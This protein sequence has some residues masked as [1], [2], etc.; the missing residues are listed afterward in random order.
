[1]QVEIAK[2]RDIR[3][4]YEIV[5]ALEKA[6][7][8]PFVGDRRFTFVVGCPD[9]VACPCVI[10][11][12]YHEAVRLRQNTG[13]VCMQPLFEILS[14]SVES[15]WDPNKTLTLMICGA[16]CPRCGRILWSAKQEK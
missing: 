1:M 3:P 8:V 16:V 14:W 15:K 2:T 11:A 4:K 7:G 9:L 5:Q 10:R 13:S 6:G 12:A